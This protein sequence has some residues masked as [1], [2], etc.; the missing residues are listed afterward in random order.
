MRVSWPKHDIDKVEQ[1]VLKPNCNR[2]KRI[3]QQIYETKMVF[4]FRLSDV[5]C[6]HMLPC[7]RVYTV[8]PW[9]QTII[10]TYLFSLANALCA[11]VLNHLSPLSLLHEK[12]LEISRIFL[13]I[14]TEGLFNPF[15]QKMTFF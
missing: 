9:S 8:A 11:I 2:L 1:A 14:S 13:D 5:R 6:C 7:E 15:P 3:T 4:S 12:Y 10:F